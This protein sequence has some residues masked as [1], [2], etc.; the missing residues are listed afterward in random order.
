MKAAFF[1]AVL[2][3]ASLIAGS[4]AHPADAVEYFPKGTFYVDEGE[5]QNWARQPSGEKALDPDLYKRFQ[6]M[7][8][9]HDAFSREWYS[10][11]LYALKEPVLSKCEI[12]P[13]IYRLTWLRSFHRP[14]SF[15]L[16]VG[17]DGTSKLLL[18]TDTAGG[19]DPGKPVFA[20]EIS[21]DSERTYF[22]IEGAHNL[23]LFK[24]PTT[25]VEQGLDGARWIIE[26]CVDGK[27]HVVDRWGG[28]EIKAWGLA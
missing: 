25:E 13:P 16:Q 1:G 17:S 14:M 5:F 28:G 27:Y 20:K 12:A 11:Q 21:F 24:L 8:E 3:L 15:R 7:R 9:R 23:N 22:F 19:Y 6:R 10:G 2:L 4:V 26:L 18:R